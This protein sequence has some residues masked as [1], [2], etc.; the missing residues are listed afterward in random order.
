MTNLLFH[1]NSL[2]RKQVIIE[3]RFSPNIINCEYG[4]LDVN[5]PQDL[6]LT[7]KAILITYM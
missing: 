2:A 3:L 6:L 1:C 5:D 7:Y 4:F